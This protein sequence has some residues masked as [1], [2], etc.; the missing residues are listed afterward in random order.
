M[1]IILGDTYTLNQYGKLIPI[2]KMN[3]KQKQ[4]NPEI[5]ENEIFKLTIKDLFICKY[6]YKKIA[7]PIMLN[8]P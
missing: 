2:G 1:K 3:V 5:I 4:Q 7:W 6:L 8:I